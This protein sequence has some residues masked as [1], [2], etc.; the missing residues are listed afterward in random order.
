[1]VP[2]VVNLV[3]VKSSSKFMLDNKIFSPVHFHIYLT[4]TSY[5]RTL[6]EEAPEHEVANITP[7]PLS[8][9]FWLS[10]LTILPPS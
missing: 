8:A 4:I 5:K 9:H 10:I 6:S 1:M 3:V 7:T 2:V